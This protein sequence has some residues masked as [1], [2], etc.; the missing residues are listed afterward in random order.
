MRK[1]LIISRL[2]G[3]RLGALAKIGIRYYIRIRSD[4]EGE[5]EGKGKNNYNYK[6]YN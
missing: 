6:A 5:G 1:G 4:G 3:A 2:R